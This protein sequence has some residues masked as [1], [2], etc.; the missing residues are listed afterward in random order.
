MN[1]EERRAVVALY[2]RRCV[3]Y[4]DASIERKVAR[5]DDP[6]EIA[7][8]QAYR[9]FSAYSA[10]EVESGTLDTWLSEGDY[11]PKPSTPFSLESSSVS[12][13]LDEMPHNERREWLAGLLMPRP[14]VLV[15]TVSAEG[16]PNLA[17][18]SSV[19]VVSNS[20]PLLAMSLSVD[21]NGRPRD[22]L[23]NLEGVGIGAQVTIFI[24]NADND[25][26]RIVDVTA[27]PL[28]HSKSEWDEIKHNP[29]TFSPALAAMHCEL[30]EINP[31]PLG[32]SSKI[33]ILR[34]KEVEIP[35]SIDLQSIPSKLFQIGFDSLG[36][37]PNS[38]DWRYG[39]SNYESTSSDN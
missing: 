9:D 11:N 19:S 28:L 18:M 36:P 22:T 34:V 12:L 32:A 27:A 23:V 10:N 3:T 4:S 20:P 35:N 13:S 7:R 6:N 14:V 21:L 15:S 1:I 5:G 24:L 8:W 39:L 31:L 38:K 33:V 25:S 16:A 2:L 30:V 26:A 29:P 17:P 37:G